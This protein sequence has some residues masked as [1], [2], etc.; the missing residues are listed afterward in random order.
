MTDNPYVLAARDVASRLHDKCGC[1]YGRNLPYSLHIDMALNAASQYHR[2]LDKLTAEEFTSTMCA[3][4]LHDVG[5]DCRQNWNDVVALMG[6]VIDTVKCDE[7]KLPVPFYFGE[8][9]PKMVAEIV[10]LC[11]DVKGRNR[12]ERHEKTYPLTAESFP[13][14]FVKIA[15]DRVANTR[16]SFAYGDRPGMHRKYANEL[17][18]LIDHFGRWE[19]LDPAFEELKWLAARP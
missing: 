7:A 15:G 16:F 12:K 2:M 4:A 10:Y 19:E 9:I 17:P 11:T 8:P 5:E 6:Q 14:S 13:A 3:V 18:S 1:V